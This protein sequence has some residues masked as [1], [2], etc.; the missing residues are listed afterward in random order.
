MDDLKII[1][2][3]RTTDIYFDSWSDLPNGTIVELGDA[4][5]M[6]E[7]EPMIVAQMRDDF[8]D[9]DNIIN[10]NSEKYLIDLKTGMIWDKKSADDMCFALDC[11]MKIKRVLNC[12]D[13]HGVRI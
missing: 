12:G 8:D 10:P 11:E 7:I 9:D 6:V 13:V 5:S 1:D 2:E 4:G 3:T